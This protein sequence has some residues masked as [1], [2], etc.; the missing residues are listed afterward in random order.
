MTDHSDHEL[1]LGTREESRLHVEV[2]T[3]DPAKMWIRDLYDDLIL[4]KAGSNSLRTVNHNGTN[5][6]TEGRAAKKIDVNARATF[7]LTCDI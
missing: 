4:F 2:P 3:I 1:S 7:C 5:P 6:R